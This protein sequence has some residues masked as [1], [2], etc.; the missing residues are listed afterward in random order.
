MV[1]R[2]L[3]VAVTIIRMRQLAVAVTIIRMRQLAVAVIMM[4]MTIMDLMVTNLQKRT[5]TQIP[6]M[7]KNLSYHS[8]NL[9]CLKCSINLQSSLIRFPS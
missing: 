6:R 1:D 8:R 7:I 9:L 3:A 4:T 5:K 2:K